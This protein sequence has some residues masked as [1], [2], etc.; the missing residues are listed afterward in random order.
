MHKGSRSHYLSHCTIT[1]QVKGYPDINDT[2]GRK[3][4]H[5]SVFAFYIIIIII[6]ITMV[7]KT[8]WMQYIV[9]AM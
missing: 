7:I 6:I 1:V 9:V 2:F 3:G 8:E 4:L 5:R